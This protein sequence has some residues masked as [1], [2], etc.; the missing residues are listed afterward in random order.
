MKPCIKNKEGKRRAREREGEEEE[1]GG[2]G[3]RRGRDYNL[4]SLIIVDWQGGDA[5]R[6]LL[7]QAGDKILLNHLSLQELF[8]FV[9]FVSIRNL[10]WTCKLYMPQYRGTPGPK[11]GR[12]E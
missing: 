7:V 9:L 5:G 3:R 6:F 12:G 8:C 10:C 11:S 4:G 2:G 1:E